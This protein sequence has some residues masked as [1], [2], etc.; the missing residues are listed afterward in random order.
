MTTA[1]QENISGFPELTIQEQIVFEQIK[2]NIKCIFELFGYVPLETRLIEHLE[3]LLEKGIDEKEVYTLCSFH[4]G[5]IK[6]KSETKQIYVLKFDLT[7][8]LARYI[9]QNYK[10]LFFPLKRYQIQQVYRGETA[11]ESLGRLKEFYQCDIDV[12]GKESLSLAYDSEFPCIIY[13][14]FKE[15]I[16]IDSFV[17]RIN[18]RKLLEGL[19][20]EYGMID[21]AQLK[22]C[23]KVIDNMEKVPLKDTTN[24]LIVLGLTIIQAQNIFKFFDTCRCSKP[25]NVIKAFQLLQVKNSLFKQGLDELSDV[26]HN[27]ISNGV[28]QQY[29]MVDPSIARGLDYYTGTVYETSLDIPYLDYNDKT[30]PPIELNLKSL[31]SVCSGGRYDDLVGALSGNK[32]DI[33]PGCGISIGL[34]RLIPSLIKVGILKATKANIIYTQL[35]T[36][37]TDQQPK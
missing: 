13:K 20:Q 3:T 4:K 19:F 10:T 11:R 22:R 23:V 17:I 5:D 14:I 8:P 35:S 15:V 26:I 31:G 33:F 28:P 37:A 7:V 36:L 24:A 29:L 30:K 27:I 34:S 1:L 2:K 21:T 25:E 6:E 18:N 16:G 12:I 9:G 32:S